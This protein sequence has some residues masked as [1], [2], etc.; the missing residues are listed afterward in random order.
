VG[1]AQRSATVS[2]L[3]GRECEACHEIAFDPE[4]ARRYAEA[5][6]RLIQEERDVQRLDIRR[7]REKLNLTQAQAA[8]LTG[9]GHNAFSR[10][11][12]GEA[13]P[14]PAVMNLFR[15]LDRHPDLINE[16]DLSSGR[17]HNPPR[18]L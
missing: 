10:Y 12:R 15:L 16:L 1:Y 11:E 6:D 4:S 17:D 8:K 14:M 18:A 7:I 3:A 2:N 13:I 5:G 9:G